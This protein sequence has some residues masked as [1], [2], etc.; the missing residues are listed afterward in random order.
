MVIAEVIHDG[1]PPNS[2]RYRQFRPKADFP[3]T[4]PLQTASAPLWRSSI[5]RSFMK[6]RS[7]IARWANREDKFLTRQFHGKTMSER[8]GGL[9]R[10]R[11]NEAK[12]FLLAMA[13]TFIIGPF[14]GK[15]SDATLPGKITLVLLAGW[16]V[17]VTA[18]G[19]FIIF[20]A[21]L[22]S[23]RNLPE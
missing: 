12:L 23:S 5:G 3:D 6:I 2:G 16:F 22:R 4:T 20:R 19:G 21:L 10:S 14:I 1:Y 13:P 18:V 9:R 8:F 11:R 15:W 7:I 17:V